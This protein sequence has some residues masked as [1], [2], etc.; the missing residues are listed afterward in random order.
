MHPRQ[1]SVLNQA[2]KIADRLAAEKKKPLTPLLWK[3]T[4]PDGMIFYLDEK[5][6][7]I[8]SPFSGKSFPARP[9]RHTPAQVGKDM[10]DDAK[11]ERATPK[12]ASDF[13]K[14]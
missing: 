1:T 10:K 4:D 6:L 7:T 12:V 2:T 8:K 3:Y 9:E 11:A 13:W 5:K 14:A